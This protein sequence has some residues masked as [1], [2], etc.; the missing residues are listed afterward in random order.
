MT[1]AFTFDL[2][3]LLSP[4]SRNSS[5]NVCMLK[6]TLIFIVFYCMLHL[7]ILMMARYIPPADHEVTNLEMPLSQLFSSFC[8]SS[9]LCLCFYSLFLQWFKHI[10][11]NI[12]FKPC[13]FNF[14]IVF[15]TL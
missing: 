15:T 11:T 1:L 8:N 2:L 10:F 6:G 3:R 12:V 4:L 5:C 7:A 9:F 13:P 14:Q